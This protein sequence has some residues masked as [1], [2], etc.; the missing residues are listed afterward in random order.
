M[1]PTETILANAIEILADG[2]QRLADVRHSRFVTADEV[3]IICVVES[4]AVEALQAAGIKRQVPNRV[5]TAG[6]GDWERRREAMRGEVFEYG[7]KR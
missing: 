1:T 4:F 7:E 2:L 6:L 3:S 5:P